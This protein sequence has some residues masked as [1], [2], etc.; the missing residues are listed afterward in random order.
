MRRVARR[1]AAAGRVCLACVLFL[2]ASIV[3]RARADVGV[4]PSPGALGPYHLRFLQGGVGSLRTLPPD[5]PFAAGLAPWSLTTW[6]KPETS[7]AGT[8]II[9]AFDVAGSE[10]CFCLK[11]VDGAPDM[12]LRDGR[13][14]RADRPLAADA[15]TAVAVTDDG[16]TLRLYVAGDELATQALEPAAPGT[17]ADL[18][19]TTAA[20]RL[21][22]LAPSVPGTPRPAHFG[23]ALAFFQLAPRALSS[24]EV[25]ALAAA[26]PD[27]AKLTMPTVGVGWPLQE[28]AWIGLTVPQDP[29]TL[30]HAKAPPDVPQAEPPLPSAPLQANGAG[31]WTLEH[32]DLLPAPQTSAD[33]ASLSDPARPAFAGRDEHWLQATVPGTVLTT[34]I[35]RGV[36]PDPDHG[37]NN[38]Q[39]PESLARQDYWYRTRFATPTISADASS[40]VAR[41][42]APRFTLRLGGVNYAAEL[43][44][45]GRRL[46]TLKGAFIRGVFDVTPLLRRHG[47]N[48]LAVRVSPPPHPGIPSEQSILYGPGENGGAL[49]LDGPTF[50]ATEGWDWIPAMRDR[51][52]GIWQAVQLHASGRVQIGD[53]QVIT[54]LPLPRTDAAT[55]RIVVPLRNSGSAP[56]EVQVEAAFD[57]V[58]VH[59][60]ALIPVGDSTLEFSPEEFAALNLQHPRLW[61]PNGYGAPDLHLLHLR[62]LEGGRVSDAKTLRFGIRELSYEL[63]LFDRA[64][65]LRRVA[66]DPSAAPGV[67][68]VDGSHAAIK[69]VPGGWAQSLTAAG[70]RSAAVRTVD[71]ESLAP[72]LVLRVNGVRIAARGGSWGMDDSR[73]RI[74]RA[75][76]EPY[77]R[78]HREAH[79][80]I[81]RNWLGQN[82]EEVFYDL[83]DEY[84]LLVL[85]DFWESTQG[86]QLEAEDPQ[87]FLANARDV[88]SRY[89]NHPSIAVWFGRNE[90]VPQPIINQGLAELVRTLDGTRLYTG[91]SNRV[92]LQDSGPYS[93]QPPEAY[94]TS[95]GRGFAVELGT[96][97]LATLESLRATIPEPDRWPIS[98]TL[99]Y[100]DWHFGGNG[101]VHSFMAAMRAQFGAPANLED[102]ERKA[103]LMNYVDYRAIFEGFAA[104]LWTQNSGR[105]L[106]M[107]H[108]AW[109]S[110]H[111]QIYSADYDTQASYY[112]VKKAAEPLHVQ[113]NLPDYALA[114]VNTTRDT[115]T[116]LT[117]RSRVLGLD[118]REL[119]AGSQSV[120]VEAN[121]VTTL[122]P[123]PLAALLEKQ[124][125]VIVALE[126]RDA[127]GRTVS[128]NVYWPARD[129][130][131]Y[132]AL[133]RLAPQALAL[134]A[135][136][137]VDGDEIL[138]E[139]AVH[140]PGSIP[141]LAAKLTLLDAA[142]RRILPAYYSDNYLNVLPGET[143]RVTLRYPATAATAAPAATAAGP[144]HLD[145]RGWNVLAGSTAI[146]IAPTEPAK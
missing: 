105:L 121:A 35:D 74:S 130:A 78:L 98:D 79:L 123:L 101:D 120:S 116:G 5:T 80:N 125:V 139:I 124:G 31:S 142:G 135:T 36:Y 24:V 134:S 144:A 11:L 129:A 82:T 12:Q 23:G 43:W 61:W 25:Q 9:A 90:G 58:K 89:R 51:D 96:P 3:G 30:P 119:F 117:V 115:R 55:V 19:G 77:F 108:P 92:N 62:V 97:S 73:K 17:Q 8:V 13:E 84:G 95:L 33:G 110:N 111:W 53:P 41:S 52:T 72:Y 112:G 118:G 54:R 141:V 64:G 48:V 32:W 44:L 4:D 20:V 45:N 70:E 104:H 138:A 10:R 103:Q 86:F 63:S 140:N 15:W 99:A 83:A 18:S 65:H 132:A 137:Q 91:S 40:A 143:R 94:F 69:Q 27:F 2:L 67:A 145:L 100:H 126:L 14:A 57:A 106:W 85:N 81:I 16:A 46:G 49:A 28:K 56:R 34:L 7:L 136:G 66:V 102:F 146:A 87:L 75:R 133:E 39:I 6:I 22:S 109:P 88:I 47:D 122:A 114:V 26:R 113:M 21:L 60:K 76:L 93:Y 131:S 68:L 50:I 59:R 29:W 38:L 42:T 37:L 1:R 71:S 128:E 127:D 107:T